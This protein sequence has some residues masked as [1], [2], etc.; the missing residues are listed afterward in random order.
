MQKWL[1]AEAI[2]SGLAT[3]LFSGSLL[4]I[5]PLPA[6]YAQDAVSEN[7]ATTSETTPPPVAPDTEPASG[8]TAPSL[9][10]FDSYTYADLFSIAVPAGWEAMEQDSSP[11][12]IL[13]S[14]DPENPEHEAVRT[15][16]TWFNEP[17]DLVVAQ[18]INDLKAN[19]YLVSRYEPESINGTTALNIWVT[20]LPDGLPNAFMTYIGYAESTAAV[21]S[22]YTGPNPSLETVLNSVHDSFRRLE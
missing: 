20:E 7:G 13:T 21:V 12:V 4:G 14:E 18:Q 11:Q 10:D 17:P 15:E 1:R 8:G 3:A 19:G 6:T 9:D 16:I 5:M 22:Y 2:G